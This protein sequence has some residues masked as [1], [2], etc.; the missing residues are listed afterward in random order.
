[1]NPCLPSICPLLIVITF[2]V[3]ESSSREY[4][5]LA[6][7]LHNLVLEHETVLYLRAQLN[8][9]IAIFWVILS[10]GFL[11]SFHSGRSMRL[12]SNK[13][14]LSQEHQ[15][16][17]NGYLLLAFPLK[18]VSS[19]AS[20]KEHYSLGNIVFCSIF[21]L[22]WATFTAIDSLLGAFEKGLPPFFTSVFPCFCE[23]PGQVAFNPLAIILNSIS[24][25]RVAKFFKGSRQDSLEDIAKSPMHS[26]NTHLDG[27]SFR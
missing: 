5:T 14:S 3:A 1:M 16:Q 12:A 20:R 10:F 13:S 22:E 23:A 11:R 27:G 8:D 6:S 4:L 21:E 18:S 24:C 15:S 17:R 9:G 7:Q 19:V 26:L 25:A 2:V